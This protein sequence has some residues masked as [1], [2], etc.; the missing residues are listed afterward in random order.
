MEKTA[1]LLV[2]YQEELA[3]LICREAGKAWK[4]SIG[5]VSRGI[6]TPMISDS[7][8][9]RAA[10]RINEAVKEGASVLVGGKQGGVFCIRRC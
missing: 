5:E 4:Y 3:T 2:K 6:E 8:A 7:E 10:A 9:K 1:Q